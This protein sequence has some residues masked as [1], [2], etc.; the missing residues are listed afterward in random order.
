MPGVAPAKVLII[1]GGVVGDN[2]AKM[3]VGMGAE[4][5]ILDRSISRLRRLD[6]DFEAGR[7]VSTL[8]LLLLRSMPQKLI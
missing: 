7:A 3:A 6:N 1:G 5:T 2:A 8:Q 4:V